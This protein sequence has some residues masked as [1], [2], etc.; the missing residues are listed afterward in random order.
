[1]SFGRFQAN[2]E[3]TRNGASMRARGSSW[4]GHRRLRER[5]RRLGPGDA[6]HQPAGATEY[7]IWTPL[8]P[9]IKQQLGV[10]NGGYFADHRCRY[11]GRAHALRRGSVADF[12][13]VN[14]RVRALWEQP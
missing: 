10:Q 13:P 3:Q 6:A 7:P 11:S 8:L 4:P 2:A 9:G 12:K 1:M 14:V 5:P